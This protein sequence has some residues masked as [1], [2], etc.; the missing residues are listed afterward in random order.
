MSVAGLM[1]VQLGFTRSLS[2]ERGSNVASNEQEL[3]RLLTRGGIIQVSEDI[4]LRR[5][6][7]IK[8]ND[9]TLRGQRLTKTTIR[10]NGTHSGI[11]I[12]CF[13]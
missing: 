7:V 13:H 1:D 8:T 9:I 6:L 12:R 10:C 4:E 2:Q 3:R 11:Q 5:P